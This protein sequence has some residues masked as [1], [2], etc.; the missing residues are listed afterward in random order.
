M[1]TIGIP[2]RSL[3]FGVHTQPKFSNEGGTTYGI[4]MLRHGVHQTDL[5]IYGLSHV[6]RI[7]CFINNRG[8]IIGAIS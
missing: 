7:S 2:I 1:I 3:T 5:P 6:N 8:M 4:V